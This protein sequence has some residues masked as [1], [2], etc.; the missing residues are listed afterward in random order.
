MPAF[1]S[2]NLLG[3]KYLT[4]SKRVSPLS[5]PLPPAIKEALSRGEAEGVFRPGIDPLQLYVGM[6]A[7]S[8]F[9]ISNAPTPIASVRNQFGLGP[10][11]DAATEACDRDDDRV[12]GLRAGDVAGVG[13]QAGSDDQL[14]ASRFVEVH[15]EIKKI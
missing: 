14:L 2:E 15:R 7:L 8:Y 1:A 5:S 11:K 6:V 3:A 10:M 9:H 13:R 4:R 12:S